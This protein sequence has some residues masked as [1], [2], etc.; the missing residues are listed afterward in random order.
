MGDASRYPPRRLPGVPLPSDI[1]DRDYFLSDYCEGATEF[2]AGRGV[3]PLK[4]LQLTMLAVEPGL[5]VLDAGCGRGEVLLACAKAGARVAGI[6]YAEAAIEISRETLADVEGAD[7]RQGSVEELPWP[8]ESFDRILC[9]DVVEHLDPDQAVR[10]FREFHRVLA[11]GGLLL[12]HTSPN[13]LFRQITW[14]LARP[15]LRLAGFRRNVEALDF[16]LDE[17]LRYHV[18]EQT[19]HS[20]RRAV[21]AGGFDKVR[22]W[23]DP[24][25][26]RGGEHHLTSGL[27]LSPF[28]KIAAYLAAMRP[29]RMFLSNDLYAIAWKPA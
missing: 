16:W 1:Y 21:R 13:R 14:P 18:N 8:D 22:V 3:S 6:D 12:I 2:H 4:A 29:F 26:I 23:L 11:P 25:V 19:V 24:N 7:V 27:E 5:R 28:A 20:L 15:I 9:G 10:A 17:A